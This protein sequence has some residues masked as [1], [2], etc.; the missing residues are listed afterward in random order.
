MKYATA[1]FKFL[2]LIAVA[3][4]L[5]CWSVLLCLI[6]LS[7]SGMSDIYL[8]ASSSLS[9][10]VMEQALQIIE[11]SENGVLSDKTLEQLA[12]LGLTESQI[13]MLESL[14]AAEKSPEEADTES[15]TLW[16]SK[17]L[18]W[19]EQ[20]AFLFVLLGIAAAGILIAIITIIRK[21]VF[22]K[23]KNKEE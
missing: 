16:T 9:D 14:A 23:P 18:S 6:S 1:K 17:K 21:L 12:K 2:K 7:V 11:D 15:N 20:P 22:M 8:S 4:L 13:E 10:E 19:F 5:F 3:I